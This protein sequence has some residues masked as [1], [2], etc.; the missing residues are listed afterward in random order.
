MLIIR[1]TITFVATALL[2]GA[3]MESRA[4]DATN[5]NPPQTEVVITKLF[6]PVYPQVAVQAQVTGNVEL[7]LDIRPDGSI[8]SANVVRGHPLLKQAALDSAMQSQFE[9]KNCSEEVKTYRLVYSFELGPT[10]YCTG[11]DDNKPAIA[12]QLYPRLSQS[13]GHVTLVAQRVATCD[14]RGPIVKVRSIKCLY[15]WRC[16][17]PKLVSYE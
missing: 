11:T 15:L 8:A 10:S 5:L 2:L 9:C 4:Q 14:L 6:T 7:M 13:Q 3:A 12:G 1:R 16:G 17:V